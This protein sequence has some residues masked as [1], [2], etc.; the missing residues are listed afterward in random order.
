MVVQSD[1]CADRDGDRGIHHAVVDSTADVTSFQ[2]HDAVFGELHT[3]WLVASGKHVHFGF[4]AAQALQHFALKIT[5]GDADYE[6]L[7]FRSPYVLESCGRLVFQIA[8]SG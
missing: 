8:H 6:W 4:Q 5:V 7:L 2:R 1:Y 3:A